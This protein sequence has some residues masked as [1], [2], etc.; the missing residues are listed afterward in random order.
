MNIEELAFK[1]RKILAN[2]NAVDL[3]NIIEFLQDDRRQCL[4]ELSK[5]HNRSVEIQKENQELKSQ[6][7]GTTHCFDEEEHNKLKE[8][9][10]N[11]SKDVDMWN[12]KYNDMFDENKM[13]KKQVEEWK[14]HLKC[15]KEMLDIQG[16]KGNYDYDEYM[17]GLYNGMEYIIA[18]FETREPN[19]INGKDVEF[20]N[21]KTQQKEFIKWL[22]DEINKL[23]E[24]IKNYDIWHEVGTD[25][26]F[27]IFEKQFYLEILQKYKRIIGD[28]ALSE[29][30]I[31]Q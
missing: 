23:K 24:Q 13:L 27:L 8:E 29:P 1:D 12:A 10:T 14:H 19:F 26:N 16:Q 15:S 17:L 4:E 31:T 20:T 18:L 3:L 22:E 30:I 21:N 11:L 9:I 28:D 6:L 7:A 25:I 2:L 5:T